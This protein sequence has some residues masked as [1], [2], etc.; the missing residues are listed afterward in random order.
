[1]P[2]TTRKPDADPDAPRI[3][4]PKDS[5]TRPIPGNRVREAQQPSL[6]GK[7]EVEVAERTTD[8]DKTSTGTYVKKFVTPK[9]AYETGDKDAVHGRNINAVRQYMLNGG[10]RP[11]AEVSFAGA[12]DHW[13]GV[14]VVLSYEVK[15]TPGAVATAFDLRHMVIPQDGP[16]PAERAEHDAGREAR[17]VAARDAVRYGTP[18]ADRPSDTPAQTVTS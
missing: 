4:D 16:T 2:P 18:E 7:P 6:F 11:N 5:G 14:S 3:L 10:L 17:V 9:A 12:E 13:D 1:M 8:T 15:A